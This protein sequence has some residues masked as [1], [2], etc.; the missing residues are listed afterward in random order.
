M[1]VRQPGL[2]RVLTRSPDVAIERREL[3][4]VAVRFQDPAES[5]LR[6]QTAIDRAADAAVRS[7]VAARVDSDPMRRVLTVLLL[8]IVS[9]NW[10]LMQRRVA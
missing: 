2:Y 10:W 5:D 1:I 6:R 3:A 8:L 4:Q 7:S 9:L